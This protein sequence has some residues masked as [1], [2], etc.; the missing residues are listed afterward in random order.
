MA[1]SDIISIM[2]NAFW[3]VVWLGFLY[4]LFFT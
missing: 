1:A 2:D 3:I 4:W